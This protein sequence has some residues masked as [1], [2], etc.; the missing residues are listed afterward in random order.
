M[1]Y[2]V[3]NVQ[4]EK[5]WY[6]V[7]CKSHH[8]TAVNNRL[9]AK[10]I[11]TYLGEVETRVQWGSRLRKVRQKMLPGYVLVQ[12]VMEARVYLEILQTA[13][14]VNFVGH[15]WPK[16]SWI[17]DTQVDSLRL[18]LESRLPFAEIP[19]WRAGDPVEVIAGPFMGVKGY[20]AGSSHRKSRVIVSIELLR[21]SVAV[22]VDA[23]LLRRSPAL[24]LAA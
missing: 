8:E 13:S 11:T 16:L 24:A 9:V 22:E 12:A 6:A 19:Y 3:E 17:P 7:Y 23:A 18:I 14:V 10:G 1:G 20:V 4:V 2:K 21:R 15:P 5:H